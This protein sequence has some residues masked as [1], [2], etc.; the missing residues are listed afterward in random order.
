[1][2]DTPEEKDNDPTTVALEVQENLAI[3]TDLVGN[4]LPWKK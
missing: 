2:D 1:M 3:K 4:K